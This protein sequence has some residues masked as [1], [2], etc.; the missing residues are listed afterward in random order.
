MQNLKLKDSD[1]S[2]Y[3]HEN[4]SRP[5]YLDA[6]C[7]ILLTGST[8]GLGSYLLD[9]LLALPQV[10]KVF[11]FNRSSNAKERQLE[12]QRTRGLPEELQ[13]RRVEFFQVN[14]EHECL[15]LSTEIYYR[16]ST[17]TDLVIHNAWPVDF[18]RNLASFKPTIIGV[19]HLIN[20]C[21]HRTLQT[22]STSKHAGNNFAQA[23]PIKLFFISSVGATSNWGSAA[24]TSRSQVPEVEIADWKV[25]RTG[26]GQSKLLS[27]RLITHAAASVGLPANIVRVGQLAGPVQKD[28]KGKWTERE[29]IPS[30]IRSSQALKAL[31]QTLGP[32]E[33]VDWVPVDLAARILCDVIVHFWHAPSQ[34]I[35]RGKRKSSTPRFYHVVNPNKATWEGLV[36]TIRT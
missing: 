3:S 2:P 26:Y 28:L 5:S 23:F 31:P 36:P 34:A 30:I 11:C 17:A 13:S 29:W 32:T 10:H 4:S 27:E 14:L 6:G 25:A 35:A 16:L 1:R 15:G 19:T 33:T 20:F 9:Q 7:A 8:G 21:M 24:P 22:Q 18:N 12:A